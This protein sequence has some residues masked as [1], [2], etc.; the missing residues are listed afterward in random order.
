MSTPEFEPFRVTKISATETPQRVIYSALYSETNNHFLED[1]ETDQNYF[2]DRTSG[3]LV[4]QHYRSLSQRD[5][6]WGDYSC[7]DHAYLTLQIKADHLTLS[8]LTKEN[9]FNINLQSLSS[10]GDAIRKS[11]D[12]NEPL[13]SIF[14]SRREGNYPDH[15][16]HRQPWSSADRENHLAISNSA[17]MDYDHQ[18]NRGISE[19]MAQQFLTVNIMQRATMTGSLRAWLNLLDY[20]SRLCHPYE[21]RNVMGLIQKH[22][23]DWSPDI[24]QW[25]SNTFRCRLEVAL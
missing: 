11:K 19:T 1:I 3:S 8:Q 24:Y 15:H 17:A 2:D 12:N 10:A 13:E 23:H 4:V 18:R 6:G 9:E 20:N 16:G 14:Y 7:L 25:W 5:P 21:M 22:V